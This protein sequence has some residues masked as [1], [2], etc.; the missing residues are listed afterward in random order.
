MDADTEL[1]VCEFNDATIGGIGNEL[2]EVDESF[3]WFNANNLLLVNELERDREER[4]PESFG[5]VIVFICAVVGVC[6]LE[7]PDVLG[8]LEEIAEEL[9]DDGESNP[10]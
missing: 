8:F 5:D 7:E 1:A 10:A 3:D 9:A 4:A 6:P 2:V